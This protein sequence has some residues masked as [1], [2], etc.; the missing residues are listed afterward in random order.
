VIVDAHEDVRDVPKKVDPSPF[1][2]RAQRHKTPVRFLLGMTRV[3]TPAPKETFMEGD[4]AIGRRAESRS[5]LRS[6]RRF[7]R[8][9]KAL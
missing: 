1:I 2:I 7:Q 5:E 3:C 4:A 6:S 9:H 8:L